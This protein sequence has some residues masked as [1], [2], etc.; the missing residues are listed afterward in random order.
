MYE[1]VLCGNPHKAPPT[2]S[3]ACSEIPSWE[4][5]SDFGEIGQWRDA[6]RAIRGVFALA[7]S[8]CGLLCADVGKRGPLV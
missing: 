6:K 4:R 2:K 1:F 3:E 5:P 8:V 7:P